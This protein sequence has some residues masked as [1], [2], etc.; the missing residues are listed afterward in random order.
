MGKQVITIKR[1]KVGGNSGY[2]T[3]NVCHGTGR[4]KVP[5][6]KT[7]TAKGKHAGR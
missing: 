7:S 5:N 6:R 2:M 3:C 4:Q 1:R